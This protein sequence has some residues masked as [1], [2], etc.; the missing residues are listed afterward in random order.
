MKCFVIVFLDSII[1]QQFRVWP[2]WRK[3]FFL[4]SNEAKLMVS[5]HFF[6]QLTVIFSFN[7]SY[8]HSIQ[9]I[10]N[11]N[12]KRDEVE[13]K[14]EF[15]LIDIQLYKSWIF[16]EI[17]NCALEC[18]ECE[19]AQDS[20]HSALRCRKAFGSA[21]ARWN[22]GEPGYFK[23]WRQVQAMSAVFR[24]MPISKDIGYICAPWRLCVK[25]PYITL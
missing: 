5:Q 21:P 10:V 6:I 17:E 15:E 23:A 7:L 25:S 24:P 13:I 9:L 18:C 4:S 11:S 20:E 12:Q 3:S 8:L 14:V 19:G 1:S 16:V 2:D 22:A